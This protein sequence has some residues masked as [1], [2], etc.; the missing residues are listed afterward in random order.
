MISLFVLRK[1]EPL[2]SRP[3][4]SPFYPWFP[5]IALLLSTICLLAIIWYNLLL[6]L[7][8]FAV[9]VIVIVVFM[10][11]KRHKAVAGKENIIF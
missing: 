6:S 11:L 7:L 4:I 1:K 10:A 5:V 3:F 2:L 9:M 8:F